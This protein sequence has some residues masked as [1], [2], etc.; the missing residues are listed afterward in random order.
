MKKIVSLLLVFVILLSLCACGKK[1]GAAV[2]TAATQQPVTDTDSPEAL[3]GHIDQTKPVDGVYKIWNADGVQNIA[4]HP[5][6]SFEL[7]CDVDMQGAQV[8]GIEVFQGEI[9][10]GN[11]II[12]NFTLVCEGE[13]YGF[14]GVNK[15]KINN[16]RLDKVTCIPGSDAKNIGVMAGVNEGSILRCTILSATLDVNAASGANC[17]SIIGVNSGTITNLE[18]NVATVFQGDNA[19][20]GGIAG[21]VTGGEIRYVDTIGALTISGENVQAGLLAGSSENVV[22]TTCAF[23]G[24]DNAL[25]GKLFTNFT[26]NEEDDESVCVVDGLWRDNQKPVLTAGQQKLRDRVVEE[27]YAMGTMVWYPDDLRHSCTCQLSGCHGIY[28]AAYVHYGIPY[29]HKGGSLSRMEYCLNEDGT[30]KDF[31][32][33][34]ADF[35]GYDAYIGNDC[36]TAILHSWWTVSNSTD[37]IRTSYMVPIHGRGTVPVGEY[38]DSMLTSTKAFT[39]VVTKANGEQ[40]MF[41]AYA[42]LRKGDAYVYIIEAGGHTRMVAEDA[43]VVRDQA[44][45]INGDYSYVI[46]HEQGNFDT[47]DEKMTT[48]SWRI[49]WKY[50]FANLLL[51]GSIPV[52]ME[53]LITGEMEVAE[54][55]LTGSVDGKF[56]M[57]TGTVKANYF[58]DSVTLKITDETGNVVMDHRMFPAVGRYYDHNFNDSIIRNYV[59]SYDMGHFATPLQNVPLENGRTY[60]YT[61]SATLATRDTFLLKE[62]SFVHGN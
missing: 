21:K 12:S 35:D 30:V 6:A 4:N 2:T 22:Y 42:L 14:A 33:D 39:E 41:E 37:F 3:F 25:N 40:T 49:N 10:G 47:D 54:C 9:Q 57:T 55:T 29:N 17:G 58:L 43:V 50:T 8:K 19:L 13:N 26:G 11:F 15:G 61:I 32:Y 18:A 60:S 38:D 5:E 34:M 24:A 51:D 44:G 36:S 7:L 27:M 20:V 52:T 46:C 62:G 59:D 1:E 28:N 23:V 48:T 45:K 16:L 31:V 53:E 56:G